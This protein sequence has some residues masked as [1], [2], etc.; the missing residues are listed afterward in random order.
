MYGLYIRFLANPTCEVMGL[1]R[2]HD[3]FSMCAVAALILK[4]SAAQITL[5]LHHSPIFT[6]LTTSFR[7]ALL[8]LIS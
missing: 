7:C 6:A 5:T 8:L 2:T 1:H 4:A 3:L